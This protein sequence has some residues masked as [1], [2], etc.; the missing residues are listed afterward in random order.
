MDKLAIFTGSA[1]SQLAKD[2][3]AYLKAPLSNALVA[4]F[5]EGEIR[6]K[7]EENVRG[8]DVFIIQPTCR[9]LTRTSWSF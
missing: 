7:I 6:V 9:P 3:C 2:I 4:R 5:S 1:H 8:K